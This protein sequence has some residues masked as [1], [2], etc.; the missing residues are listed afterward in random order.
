MQTK[1]QTEMQFPQIATLVPHAAPMLLLD[2]VI[3]ADA[4][5]LCAEVA[6][7]DD[8]LFQT[9]AGVGAW[10]GIEYM[11]QAIAAWAGYHAQQR[12]EA[13]KIGFLLGARRYD[14]NVPCFVTGSTLHVEVEKLL[15]ADNG[16]GSFACSIKDADSQQQLAQATI[17]VFQPHDAREFLQ[18]GSS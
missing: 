3:S 11:A 5:K 10:V 12:G 14:A 6:I 8:S 4:D 16:L 9:G 15:Q 7:A 17:S 1:M 13:V 2:R 18:E